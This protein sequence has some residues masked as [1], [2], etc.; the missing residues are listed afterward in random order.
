MLELIKPYD[1]QL[2]SFL[3]ALASGVILWL[4][5]RRVRL[6]WAV[7][8]RFIHTINNKQAEESDG[9]GPPAKE[10]TEPVWKTMLVE[11]AEYIIMNDGRKPAT[12]LKATF[13]YKPASFEV[14]PQRAFTQEVNPNGKLIVGFDGL[15]PKEQFTIHMLNVNN[16][17][18]D[19]LGLRCNEVAGVGIPTRPMRVW[20]AAVNIFAFGIMCLGLFAMFYLIIQTVGWFARL[21]GAL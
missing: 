16:Q 2:V 21:A 11:S 6:R 14:W 5:Q 19:L 15:A 4:F 10:N 18:P 20:P 7:S 13:N 8:H 3:L 12:N 9:E 17:T 1:A